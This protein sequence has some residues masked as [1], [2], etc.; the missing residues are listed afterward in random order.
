V[1]RKSAEG[2]GGR[3]TGLTP[4]G[5]GG[6]RQKPERGI[7]LEGMGRRQTIMRSS[8]PDA[9]LNLVGKVL[10]PF[11]P[12]H[13]TGV[14]RPT[15]SAG[16]GGREVSTTS[17]LVVYVSMPKVIGRSHWTEVALIESFKNG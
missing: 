13:T 16:R 17:S 6:P 3:S 9:C 14:L 1:S 15:S 10:C 4:T 7:F 8:T 11:L 12:L 2:A 5:I